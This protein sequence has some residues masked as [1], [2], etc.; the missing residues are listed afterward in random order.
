M[1]FLLKSRQGILLGQHRVHCVRG[2]GPSACIE[3]CESGEPS[4]ET[5]PNK[6]A[7][8]HF[9]FRQSVLDAAAVGGN[10]ITATGLAVSAY[11]TG[12]DHPR[13][14]HVLPNGDVLVAES[15]TPAEHDAGSG[16]KGWIKKRVMK[17]A[18]AGVP[19]P[20][21]ITLLRGIGADGL[22]TTRT[23]FLQGLHSPF[24]MALV[25]A[26]FYVANTDALV[27]FPY[28]AGQ[29]TITEPGTKFIDLPAGNINH[30]WTKDLIVYDA[31]LLAKHYRDGAFIGQHGSWNRKPHSGYKV[32]FVGFVD[33]QPSGRPQDVL[34]G[35]LSADGHARGRPV[36]IAVDRSG[37]VLVADDVG[38]VIWRVIP[39]P[40]S[41]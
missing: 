17:N 7:F 41:R 8:R 31:D 28:R 9:A 40:P 2:D 18:G 15:N 10:D 36:G 27:R 22:A 30:H 32:V 3:F 12:L 37:A 33:G 20:D 6:A 25:G 34:T 4:E 35:F 38:N 23:V 16:L 29:T 13:M 1:R 5:P 11:A 19:S 21:R 24:G 39:L 26:Y 14:L